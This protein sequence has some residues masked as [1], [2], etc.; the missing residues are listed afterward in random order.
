MN[1]K[2]NIIFALLVIVIASCTEKVNLK[3]DES[4]TRIVVDGFIR[5]DTGE[6]K[7]ILTKS[8]EYFAN[9]P[10]PRV[11]NAS[12]SLSD[13]TNSIPLTETEPGVSGVYATDKNFAGII[14]QN[15]QL[16]IHLPEAVAGNRDYSASSLLPR[17]TKLD[18]I[19]TIFKDTW[20]K[21]GFWQV[22]LYAQDPPEEKNYYLL[23]LYRNG[24]LWS[25]TITKVGVSDDTF[26]Q[27]NYIDGIEVFFID[28]SRKYQTLNVGDT[29]MLE[30]SGITKEYYDFIMQVQQAGFNIPFFSGPP[31]NV[32]GNVDHGGVG[33]FAAYS[34]SFSTT[35]VK[36]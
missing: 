26:F 23:N 13:G 1:R 15:Y 16:N 19:T 29:I 31:A 35:V 18:S 12:V 24:K 14:G 9:V 32:V 17:V 2:L 10:S 20:G 22:K 8:S 11:I 27:G 5:S 7:I 25:D 28:N 33:F 3:L 36:K 6:Y 34:S 30:L 4:Y 21:E